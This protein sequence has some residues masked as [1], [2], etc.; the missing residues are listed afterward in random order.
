MADSWA[1]RVATI[2]S[3]SRQ[4]GLLSAQCG[5][6]H[7]PPDL[8][9]LTSYA[10]VHDAGLKLPWCGERLEAIAKISDRQYGRANK[11]SA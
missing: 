3:R 7:P 9:V 4:R 6:P 5:L 10:I 11:K 2:K 8:G 1:G